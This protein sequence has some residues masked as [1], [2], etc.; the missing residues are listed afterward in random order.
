[1]KRMHN[2]KVFLGAVVLGIAGWTAISYAQQSSDT[3]QASSSESSSG[4]QGIHIE[5]VRG[6]IYMISGA[7]GNITASVGPDGVLLVN[8]GL[9]STSDQVLATVNQLNDQLHTAGQP[10]HSF[11]PPKPIRYILNTSSDL[12]NVGGNATIAAAGIT[13]NGGNVAGDV[14]NPDAGAAVYTQENVQTR[15]TAEV[16]GKR[17]T[18]E[19][20]WPTITYLRDYMKLS[21][22]FNGE[23]VELLY[24]PSAHSNGDSIVWFRGS[25]VMSVG[26]IIDATKYPEIN[27]NE[28]GSIQGELDA[29]NRILDLGFAKWRMEEGT[30]IVPE[31]G[32]VLELA[33]VAYYRDMLTIIRDR[34]QYYMKQNMTLEQIEATKP[35]MDYDPLYGNSDRFVEAIYTCLKKDPSPEGKQAKQ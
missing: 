9:A 12:D 25:D 30:L 33:D 4:N 6:H 18:P 10:V 26:N 27:L 15:M 34:V 8:T 19:A 29:L 16:N 31:H 1:M 32:R 28:G 2:R 11:S 14:A 5:R 24:Q 21:E 7:G 20:G 17:V 3:S 13:F 35:T 22:Y 23:G